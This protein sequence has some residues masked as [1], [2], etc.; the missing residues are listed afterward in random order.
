MAKIRIGFVSNSLSS[1]FII[2]NDNTFVNLDEIKQKVIQKVYDDYQQR[3]IGEY[4]DWYEKHPD[5]AKYDEE[6]YGTLEAINE[7]V[8]VIM[9]K[10]YEWHSFLNEFY[11]PFY[12]KQ[13]DIIIKDCND[14]YFTEEV[15]EWI[16]ET[17]DIDSSCWHM[18]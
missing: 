14:N 3:K 12:F 18:G 1:S 16:E 15:K 11:N 8:K 5:W 9:Y 10:D 7:N 13:N 4:K 2:K 17:F 6:Q